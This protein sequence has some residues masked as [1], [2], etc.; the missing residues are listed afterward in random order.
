MAKSESA[1][2]AK[3]RAWLPMLSQYGP[4]LLATC[5]NASELSKTLVTEWLTTYM[6]KG[7]QDGAQK[8]KEIGDWLG[9]HSVLKTHGRPIFRAVAEQHKLKIVELLISQLN[10]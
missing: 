4:D 9:S 3:V 6:F 1:D 2:P 5:I 8:A 10:R 7:D